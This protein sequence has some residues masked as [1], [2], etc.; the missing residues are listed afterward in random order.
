MGWLEW[1]DD[2]ASNI[3]LAL[4]TIPSSSINALVVV[5]LEYYSSMQTRN[6]DYVSLVAQHRTGVSSRWLMLE[7]WFVF[8][9]FRS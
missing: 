6:G 5:G 7:P 2:M 9:V 1:V 8:L 3:L 4:D